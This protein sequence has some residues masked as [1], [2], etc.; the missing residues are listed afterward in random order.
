MR[1]L[2]SAL[3]VFVL[4]TAA[5]HSPDPLLS[6]TRLSVHTLVREDIFA[7]FTNNNMSA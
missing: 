1:P 4:V 2:K 5:A 7:G 3:L 6:E